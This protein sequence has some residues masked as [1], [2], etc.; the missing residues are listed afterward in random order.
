[1]AGLWRL[2]HRVEGV[3]L[4]FNNP[5]REFIERLQKHSWKAC[6]NGVDNNDAFVNVGN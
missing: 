6:L 2:H 5:T 4:M 3:Y 1:M